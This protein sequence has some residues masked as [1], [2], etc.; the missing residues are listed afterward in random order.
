LQL[1]PEVT[2]SQFGAL[3]MALHE[4]PLA[5]MTVMF[6][7]TLPEPKDFPVSEI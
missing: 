3:L 6:P 4:Q 2:V 1:L 7:V 5:V